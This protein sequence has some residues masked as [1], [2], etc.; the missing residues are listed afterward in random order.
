MSDYIHIDNLRA[1]FTQAISNVLDG[2]ADARRP[3]QFVMN[4]DKISVEVIVLFE[5]N[6][7]STEQE[8]T[9]ARVTET[10]TDTPAVITTNDIAETGESTQEDITN[11]PSR[12]ILTSRSGGDSSET[13]REYEEFE[14]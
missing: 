6:A 5:Q 12:T 1:Y 14:D 2:I 11:H 4:P 7:V 13:N 9:P 10:I 3:N 8:Q